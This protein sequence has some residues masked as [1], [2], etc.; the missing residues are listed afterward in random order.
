MSIGSIETYDCTSVMWSVDGS[1]K[2]KT[3]FFWTIKLCHVSKK[4]CVENWGGEGGGKV[5]KEGDF[6]NK[7]VNLK[8]EGINFLK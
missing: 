6:H 5:G 1:K 7:K 2:E 3:F 8:I 4:R